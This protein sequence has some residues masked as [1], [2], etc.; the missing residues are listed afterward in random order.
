[1]ASLGLARGYD[2]GDSQ[3]AM[4]SR[5]FGVFRAAVL[6]GLGALVLSTH[7]FVEIDRVRVKLLGAATVASAG[8]LAVVHVDTAA[9]PELNR[10]RP[11]FALIA[12]INSQ[13]AEPSAFHVSVDDAQTC[14]RRVAAGGFRRID[15][16]VSEGW[17]RTPEHNLAIQGPP[18]PWTLAYL[19]IATHHGGTT[20]VHY[21]V[22]LP[23]SSDR[24]RRPSLGWVITTWLILTAAGLWLPTARRMPRWIRALYAVM[25]GA[26]VLELAGSQVS[27]W[28]SEY[29][30][31]LSA[32]TFTTWMILLFA[33]RLWAAV[34]LW[35]DRVTAYLAAQ[36]MARR[37]LAVTVIVL[38]LGTSGAAAWQLYLKEPVNQ[39]LATWRVERARR[40]LFDELQPVKLTNCDFKRF[41]EP[42]DGGYVM[43]ANLLASVQSGYSYG[44]SGYDGW[45]CDVSR[46]LAVPVH[47]YDCFD[48]K[49]PVCAGGRTV[50]HEECIGPERATIDGRVFDNL[51][52]QFTK[53]GDLA[54]RL[55]VKMDVEGAE[56]DTLLRTPDAVLQRIDQLTIEL[57]GIGDAER[58]M[59]VVDKLKR[60]FYIANLHFNN[61]TC[62]GGI[63]P[64]P[65]D[66][67]EV[68]FVSR[69]IGQPAGSGRGGA[70]RRLIAPNNPGL[71]DCQSVANLPPDRN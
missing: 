51:Q 67:Y 3:Q 56:W 66:V 40:R 4:R 47:Q 39:Y 44:I 21:L 62:R 16:T 57:H 5:V 71:N 24:Y 68:L 42:N 60:V 23:G 9:F 63:A 19:E 27:Q 46:D 69:R 70:P 45:G 38:A 59:A 26:I 50:F 35:P 58:I 33:P 55:V 41:G 65:A 36:P 29:R 49:R 10:L 30:V 64:F 15:C 13:A 8:G 2:V 14:E 32:G 18:V 54:K 12:R 1:M 52:S 61:F 48:L 37:S 17:N 22:V 20:G 11:P 34:R 31:V 43:C 25:A 53:N 28:I 7:V 6:A